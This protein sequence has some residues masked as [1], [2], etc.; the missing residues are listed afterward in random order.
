MDARVADTCAMIAGILEVRRKAI[1]TQELASASA[2]WNS[3]R[4]RMMAI[5]Q[6]DP[7]TV[8]GGRHGTSTARVSLV[9]LTHSSAIWRG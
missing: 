6:G 4:H 9:D 1:E 7:I 2:A 3:R 5:V 8:R